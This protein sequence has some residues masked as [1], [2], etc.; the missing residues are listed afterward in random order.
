MKNTKLK[1]GIAI[2][3]IGTTIIACKKE[4][5][6]N[7][8]SQ[9][10]LPAAEN[11]T[12]A[13]MSSGFNVLALRSN[14]SNEGEISSNFSITS[15]TGVFTSVKLG[16][17][18]GPII[19]DIT[20][21]STRANNW[22]LPPII[23]ATTGASSNYPGRILQI[24]STTKVAA[25]AGFA[26]TLV[27]GLKQNIYLQDIER[28]SALG[29]AKVIYYAIE[30]GTANIYQSMV[31]TT[32]APLVWY[33]ATASFPSVGKDAD[34]IVLNGLDLFVD[35]LVVYSNKKIPGS[36]Y[37]GIGY[38]AAFQAT[39]PTL[40]TIPTLSSSV[41][42]PLDVPYALITPNEDAAILISRDKS[43]TG[44]DPMLVTPSQSSDCFIS[45]TPAVF[46]TSSAPQSYAP[47]FPTNSPLNYS[48]LDYTY[49]F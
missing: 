39:I 19:K 12:V 38:G 10:V 17:V 8:N 5:Q 3:A 27:G 2:I 34:G 26:T 14:A 15:G 16:S 9:E 42:S 32:S 11:S 46:T 24:N 47:I 33:P 30:V 29:S 13:K 18:S 25:V 49:A 28:Y 35:I 4:R 20:G 1:I 23:Y 40:L 22:P 44:S 43:L 36:P 37:I 7:L 21:I 6:E 41:E 48:M 45:T 31:T